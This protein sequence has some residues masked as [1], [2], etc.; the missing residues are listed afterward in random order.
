MSESEFINVS[1]L[2]RKM[3]GELLSAE[4]QK[5]FDAWYAENKEHRL[6]YK[7]FCRQQEKIMERQC[8]RV[9]VRKGYASIRGKRHRYMNRW[10]WG[11]IA[12]SL[13]LS[14]MLG[15]VYW[16]NGRTKNVQEVNSGSRFSPGHKNVILSLGGGQKIVIDST[17]SEKTVGHDCVAMQ[18]EN[19]VLRYRQNTVITEAPVFNELVVPPSGEYI[20]E[21]V[22]GTKI[23]LNSDSRLRYPTSFTGMNERRVFLEG[24][25]Y[26]VVYRDEKRPFIV[27]TLQEEVKVFGT[28]FNV[29]AYRDEDVVQTTLV[30]GS[31]G[32]NV[33]GE[34]K[35]VFRRI[36]PGE[37]FRLHKQSGEVRIETVDVFS[38]VA[39]KDGLF[40]SR[41]DDLESIMRKVARWYDV[42]VFYQNPGLK[43][44]RFFGIMKK[45]TC[46]DEVLEIIAKAGDVQ[47]NVS[48]R[49]VIVKE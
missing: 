18:V 29:M 38:Y 7:R 4:E 28:E 31:V 47:F 41:N 12:A 3:T 16:Q 34:R 22:D 26:F 45:Q 8:S 25:A 30:K 21:L 17:F 5:A 44:K 49:T 46:L 6:Y 36:V 33:K 40:V 19:G 48:G 2:Y 1:L 35:D 10:T 14:V 24:E 20:V 43:E 39:W 15:T 32:I 27:E 42:E 37:Q 13:L 9:D 11:G 23:Y